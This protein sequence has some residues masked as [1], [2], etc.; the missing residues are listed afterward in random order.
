VLTAT[1]FVSRVC[2]VP[3]RIGPWT[4][5][6]GK[7]ASVN[8]LGILGDERLYPEPERF[9]PERFLERSFAATEFLPFGGGQRRCLGAAFAEAELALAL[10]V[11]ATEWELTLEDSAPE[12]AVRKNLT[13]GP[14]RGVPIRVQGRRARTLT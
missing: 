8:L 9:R 10:A 7:I 1:T 13:M 11:I 6:A 2:R 12:R 3:V 5:P 14:E 4:V